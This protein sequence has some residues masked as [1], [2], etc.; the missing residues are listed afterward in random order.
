MRKEVNRSTRTGKNPH[1]ERDRT[2]A[3]DKLN[4]HMASTL[5]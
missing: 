5:G 4:P 2:N 1:G 3:V